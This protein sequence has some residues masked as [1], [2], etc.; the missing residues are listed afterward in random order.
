MPI[1]RPRILV[2]EEEPVLLDILA[3][4][5]ELLGYEVA[6]KDAADSALEWLGENVADLIA[7]GHLS[8][9]DPIEFL[10]HLSDDAS[11]SETPLLLLSADS[12]LDAVQR[13]YNAGADEYLLTPFD[14]MI[15][16]KKVHDLLDS[17]AVS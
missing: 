3:F 10:N 14:P 8:D 1:R 7:V 2:V 6:T 13:A 17:T 16:E 9:M 4:R 5:L 12:D 15:L 11:T